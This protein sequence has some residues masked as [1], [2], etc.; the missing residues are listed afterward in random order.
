MKSVLAVVLMLVCAGCDPYSFRMGEASILDARIRSPLATVDPG[1]FDFTVRD[2]GLVTFSRWGASQ[3]VSAMYLRL[4]R[5]DGMRVSLRP[6]IGTHIESKGITVTFDRTGSVI[7]S[8]GHEIARLPGTG[9]AQDSLIYLHVYSD[10]RYLQI[11]ADCDT[12]LKAHMR[13]K[14]SDDIIVQALP[15]SEASLIAPY[16]EYLEWF[17]D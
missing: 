7:D 6:E 14:E 10:S 9:F 1:K 17:A 15:S 2:T 12:L 13:M 16:W 11:I 3:Y 4:E 8:L 5:G